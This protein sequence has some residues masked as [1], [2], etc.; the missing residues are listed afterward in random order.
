MKAVDVNAAFIRE[1]AKQARDIYFQYSIF[2]FNIA[3]QFQ[4]SVNLNQQLIMGCD[5]QTDTRGTN[6]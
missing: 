1:E 5:R 4:H 6:R 2:I 3:L